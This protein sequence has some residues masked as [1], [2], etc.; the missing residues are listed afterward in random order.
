MT[1]LATYFYDQLSISKILFFTIKGLSPGII[2][3]W[4][5]LQAYEDSRMARPNKVTAS[6]MQLFNLHLNWLNCNFKNLI[7]P[8]H[9]KYS[10]AMCY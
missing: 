7:S 9:I 8:S 5:G 4:V 10:I 3:L 2:V 6:Y 1:L